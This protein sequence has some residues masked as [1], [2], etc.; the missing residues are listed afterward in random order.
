M[1]TCHRAA[2]PVVAGEPALYSQLLSTTSHLAQDLLCR[3]FWT[4]DLHKE[5][6]TSNCCVLLQCRL[7]QLPASALAGNTA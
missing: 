6:R 7:S 5:C 1:C 2:A 4:S 3:S